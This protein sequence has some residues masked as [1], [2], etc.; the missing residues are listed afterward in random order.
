MHTR[1]QFEQA[2]DRY[3]TTGDSSAI[4]LFFS[5]GDSLSGL[6][7]EA[8]LDRISLLHRSCNYRPEDSF[9]LACINISYGVAQLFKLMGETGIRALKQMIVRESPLYRN[10]ASFLITADE[11]PGEQLIAAIQ[12]LGDLPDMWE[13][14]P[15]PTLLSK[16]FQILFEKKPYSS[17]QEQNGMSVSDVLNTLDLLAIRFILEHLSEHHSGNLTESFLSDRA[18]NTGRVL[19][20][21]PGWHPHPTNILPDTDTRLFDAPIESGIMAANIRVSK[22]IYKNYQVSNGS[23]LATASHLTTFDSQSKMVFGFPYRWISSVSTDGEYTEIKF[24]DHSSF[25]ITTAYP[26]PGIIG[27]LATIT[28]PPKEK[29]FHYAIEQDRAETADNFTSLWRAFFNQVLD[30][31]RKYWQ[32]N[33]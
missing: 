22:V 8:L 2:L 14:E 29:L 32:I 23:M 17:L 33:D 18:T 11:R 26:K 3:L 30:E 21:I 24:R 5:Y 7:V 12:S 31:N 20:N 10:V 9:Y 25:K 6:L 4:T 1:S 19:G 16:P 13:D 15:A 27:A 28:A